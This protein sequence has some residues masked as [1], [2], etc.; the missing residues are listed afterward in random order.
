MFKG[1]HFRVCDEV[2]VDL[3][4]SETT[5]APANGTRMNIL[6]PPGKLGLVVDSPPDGG[7]PCVS[8][9]KDYCPIRGKIR[10]GDRLVEVDSEDVTK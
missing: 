7:L 9:V 3:V 4:Y 2:L 6:A 1:L 8:D 10:L 5:P